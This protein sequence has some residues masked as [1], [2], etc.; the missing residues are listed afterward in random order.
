MTGRRICILM[1]LYNGAQFLEDQLQSFA[2][3]KT[4]TW[5]LVACDDGS[6]DDSLKILN[7]FA[8]TVEP[9]GHQ[10]TH[11]Q[12]PR[13]GA[14]ANFL[15][16]MVHAPDVDFLALSDQDDLWLP[17][18]LQMGIDALS[19]V[20]VDTPALYGSRTWI[21]DE[22]L[23]NRRLSPEF[24]HPPSF[25]NALVQSIAGGNTMLLNRAALDLVRAA[26]PEA[27]TTGGPVTHDWWLYQLITGVG[28]QVIRDETPSLLYR[29]HGGNLFGT[30]LGRRAAMHRIGRILR[31]DLAKWMDANLAALEASAHRL[32]PENRAVLD[33]FRQLR[34]GGVLARIRGFAALGLRRQSRAAQGALWLALMI[35][36]L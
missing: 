5:D 18:R 17:D 29:Q 13:Q 12:G 19:H 36:R 4:P 14:T 7:R 6:T 16:G 15:T 2:A 30:N 23:E 22:A 8:R 3:Q 32:T 1:G 31:G 20:P 10:V 24:H 28:G 27:L 25:R 35:G 33:A 21:T 9:L 26:A 34:T 11:V